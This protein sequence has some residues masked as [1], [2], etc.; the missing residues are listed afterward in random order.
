[1]SW[2]TFKARWDE[3]VYSSETDVCEQLL[4]KLREDLVKLPS[5]FKYLDQH[6]LPIKEK[7]MGP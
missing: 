1:M 2:P 7:F 5:I 4:N 3:I 6:V